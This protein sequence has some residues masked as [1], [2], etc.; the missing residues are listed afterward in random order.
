MRVDR[1]RGKPAVTHYRLLADFGLAALLAVEPLTGRTHQ[2]RIHLADKA[3]PLAVDPLYGSNRPIV[4]SDFKPDFI[5][6]KGRTETP[7]IDRLTLHA[8][9]IE[10]PATD[11]ASGYI[12]PLDKKF[13]ATIKMLTKHNSKGP[14]AFLNKDHFSAILSAR[15]F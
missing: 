5:F 15:A 9:R 13:A 4:L 11:A 1:K 7:L 3:M 10:I 2:I 6:K 14:E 8:Y 12:A